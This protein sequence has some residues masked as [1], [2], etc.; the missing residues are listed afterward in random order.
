MHI[1]KKILHFVWLKLNICVSDG[2]IFS[3][4][5]IMCPS[6]MN[7][8]NGRVDFTT[9]VGDTATYTCDDDYILSG[10]STRL[11]LASGMWS[12]NAPTCICKLLN[13]YVA[14]LNC[15]NY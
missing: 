11:C 9:N 6:L 4:E 1:L 12:G 2:F 13:I 8:E 10:D 5:D 3:G 7:P 14:S 15:N